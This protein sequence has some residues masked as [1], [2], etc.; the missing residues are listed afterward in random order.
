MGLMD[1]VKKK[2]IIPLMFDMH[3]SQSDEEIREC[4][5]AGR[6]FNVAH[7]MGCLASI[8]GWGSDPRPLHEIPEAIALCRRLSQLGFLSCLHL[9]SLLDESF[10]GD[11]N[12]P[13]GAFEFWCVAMKKFAYDGRLI[14]HPI[15]VFQEFLAELPQIN[16]RGEQLIEGLMVDGSHKH[17]GRAQSH[18]Q[19]QQDW[20]P[21]KE[22]FEA[23]RKK[24]KK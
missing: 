8:G 12:V 24:E 13:Y 17:Q 16:E 11:L 7:D 2:G 23:L 22:V 4:L 10:K 21:F 19:N 14:G 5:V 6:Q 15:D 1:D 20:W 3:H 18:N 9:T